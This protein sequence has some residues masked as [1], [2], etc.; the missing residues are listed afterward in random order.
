[1]NTHFIAFWIN[2]QFLRLKNMTFVDGNDNKNKFPKIKLILTTQKTVW[3]LARSCR[4]MRIVIWFWKYDLMH[5]VDLKM[6]YK[7][8]A[9]IFF[10][11]FILIYFIAFWFNK[12]FFAFEQYDV[13]WWKMITK[14]NFPRSF[15]HLKKTV[16][17]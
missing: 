9:I 3:S 14:K 1:M 7:E 12:Q 15:L 16:W 11:R 13:C 17:S 8:I 2:K 10:T 4:K 6:I 5:F